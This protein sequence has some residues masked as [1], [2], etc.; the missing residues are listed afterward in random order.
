MTSTCSVDGCTSLVKCRGWCSAH[1]TRWR[2]NGDPLKTRRKPPTIKR[3][4]GALCNVEGCIGP[5]QKRDMCNMHYQR[6]WKN[7]DAGE[8]AA[9]IR[10][11]P[12]V[13]DVRGCKSVTVAKGL[14]SMHYQRLKLW[15]HVGEAEST[16][17]GGSRVLM[18]NGYVKVQ[19][20][21]HPFSN[22][23]GY[24]L[25]H[26]LVMETTL[27][28]YLLPRENVHHRNGIRDDNRPENLE[29][30][31]KAQPVG[32]RAEDLVAFVVDTYSDL[33]REALA[34]LDSILSRNQ[35]R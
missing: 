21:E 11:L 29:L 13:C 22:S 32:Q 10:P 27:G 26:R 23:D 31:V 14:C 17:P 34:D 9:R 25:E 33:V 30:W 20:P 19:L 3:Y 7:G 28:R 16:R 12:E 8:A 18:K 15:G 35:H 2:R 1:Y 24:I 5:A 6:V 4:A